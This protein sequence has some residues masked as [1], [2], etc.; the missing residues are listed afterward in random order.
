MNQI[1]NDNNEIEKIYKNSYLN[2]KV[3]RFTRKIVAK[4]RPNSS[5][6]K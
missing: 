1:N 2:Q 4:N 5:E 3:M 6:K